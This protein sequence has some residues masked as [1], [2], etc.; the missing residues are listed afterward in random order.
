MTTPGSVREFLLAHVGD[1]LGA[2]GLDPGHVPDDLDL[3]AE[4]IL[5]SLGLV[6]LIGALED[7]FGVELDFEGLDA[8]SF[9]V[10]GPFARHISEQVTSRTGSR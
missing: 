10:V 9:A 3:V 6:E 8:D 1:R 7:R 4:G 5:D 2:I